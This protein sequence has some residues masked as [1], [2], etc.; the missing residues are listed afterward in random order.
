MSKNRLSDVAFFLPQLQAST[1]VPTWV[2]FIVKEGCECYFQYEFHD[3]EFWLQYMLFPEEQKFLEEEFRS[4]VGSLGLDL[5]EVQLDGGW[6][7]LEVPVGVDVTQA[8]S[9][10]LAVIGMSCNVSRGAKVE[11]LNRLG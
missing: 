9:K 2:G 11:F 5:K 10:S 7:Y 1:I 8:V 6:S 4:A 3:G